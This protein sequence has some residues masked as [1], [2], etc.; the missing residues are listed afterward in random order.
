MNNIQ[1]LK[2]ATEKGPTFVSFLYQKKTTGEVA[3]Y[4]LN[5]GI[6]YRA[7]VAEDCEKL[8][9][10]TPNGELEIQAKDEMLKSMTETLEEGVSS[11]YTQKDTYETIAKGI[12]QHKENGNIY[13]AGYVHSKEQVEP[14]TKEEKPVNSR[15]LTLAKNSIKKACGFRHTKFSTFILAPEN[16]GGVKV[17]GQ[18][19][20]IHNWL[21]FIKS[22]AACHGWQ[23][24]F[25]YH[26]EIVFILRNLIRP[27]EKVSKI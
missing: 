24:I 27:G 8:K 23:G 3:R 15:P 19:L 26:I 2:E 4:T 12:R 7:A 14:P 6:D 25:F 21:L 11:S 20:E 22:P 9:A 18:I 13:I 5:F 10:Y 1:I 17:K 16:I